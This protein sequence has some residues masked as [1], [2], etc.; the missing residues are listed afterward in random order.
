MGRLHLR[1]GEGHPTILRLA[2]I[3]LL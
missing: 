1:K 2:E 3:G